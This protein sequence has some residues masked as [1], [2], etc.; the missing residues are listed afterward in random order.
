[1]G[2]NEPGYVKFIMEAYPLVNSF[3]TPEIR[4]YP[5]DTYRQSSETAY[6]TISQFEELLQIQY[7]P[8]EFVPILPA[9][10]ASQLFHAKVKYSEA[11]CCKWMRFITQLG[12]DVSLVNNDQL[13][14]IYQGITNDGQYLIS[15]IF[16]VSHPSLPAEWSDLPDNMYDIYSDYILETQA[17]LTDYE[18][19]SYYPSLDDLDALSNSIIF[20]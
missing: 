11:G 6:I 1:M 7:N 9:H 10:G 5:L 20:K 14:Y 15:A 18:D 17:L 2:E 8:P 4:V 19:T 3:Q 12:Q 16:P 13:V